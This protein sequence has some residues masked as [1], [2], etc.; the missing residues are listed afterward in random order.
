MEE[1][2]I[3]PF[4]FN[5]LNEQVSAVMMQYDVRIGEAIEPLHFRCEVEGVQRVMLGKVNV[6]RYAISTMSHVYRS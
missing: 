5:G 2:W 1:A 4:M 6:S 3:S